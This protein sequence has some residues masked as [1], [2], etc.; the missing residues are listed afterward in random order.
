M[1][2]FLD[3]VP[4]KTQSSRGFVDEIMQE[5]LHNFIILALMAQKTFASDPDSFCS[6]SAKVLRALELV[7][8]HVQPERIIQKSVYVN[9][10]CTQTF[11]VESSLFTP[12]LFLGQRLFAFSSAP[13]WGIL[14]AGL[15]LTGNPCYVTLGVPFLG[16]LSEPHL[17]MGKEFMLITVWF[18]L[19]SVESSNIIINFRKLRRITL[20]KAMFV[21]LLITVSWVAPMI[22]ILH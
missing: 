11:S 10:N 2:L 13:V 14:V 15:N 5:R 4:F 9:I 8:Q 17:A 22:F 20:P 16:T 7:E 12:Y 21:T 18:Q 1:S 6:T 3:W 19:F